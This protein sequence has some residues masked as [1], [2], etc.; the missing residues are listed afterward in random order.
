[1][2]IGSLV[3]ALAAGCRRA[4]SVRVWGLGG[5]RRGM[6]SECRSSRPESSTLLRRNDV[7]LD[8]VAGVIIL[9]WSSLLLDVAD[10]V[11]TMEGGGITLGG[12]DDKDNVS[13]CS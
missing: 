10:R 3:L 7:P 12:L 1:M 11:A 13:G 8:T 4:R 9:R 5:K 2:L 6:D